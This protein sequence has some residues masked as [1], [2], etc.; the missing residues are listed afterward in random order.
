MCQSTTAAPAK[1]TQGMNWISQHKRLA[2][3]LRDGL[4]CTY[5]GAS[6]EEGTKLTLDHLTPYSLG[7]SNKETNLVTCC[8]SCNSA[9]G[10]RDVK[11]FAA[12]VAAYKGTDAKDILAGIRNRIRRVLP[13]AEA[14]QM[15]ARRGSC[16]KALAEL[17]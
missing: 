14:K 11:T 17:N 6:V 2:I 1:R 12:G 5:C 8:L 9:R 13:L 7:G 10:N 16:A 4:A 15:V 3:Y